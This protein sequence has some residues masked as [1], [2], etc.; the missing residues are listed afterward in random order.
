MLP[1]CIY[2]LNFVDEII[3]LQRRV[4]KIADRSKINRKKLAADP[5]VSFFFQILSIEM[6]IPE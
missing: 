5:S 2:I 1:G 4:W 6:S 3:Y